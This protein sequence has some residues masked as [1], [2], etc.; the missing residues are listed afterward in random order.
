MPEG[1]FR[2]RLLEQAH[3]MPSMR[4]LDI[5]CGTGT[6]L[7]RAAEAQ[8]A[9]MLCGVDVDP[10]ILQ[11]ALKKTAANQI[12]ARLVCARGGLLPFRSESVDRA[13]STLMLHHLTQDEKRA[14]LNEARRVLRPRGELHIADWGPPHSMAMRIASLALRSFEHHD[15]TADNLS[16]LLPQLC[17]EAGFLDVRTT[18]RFRTMF[19]TLEL[20]A[21][22]MG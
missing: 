4:I 22:S 11:L 10:S 15:R 7:V 16:G 9:L 5:G 6:L 2:R 3:L 21:A 1:T 17:R 12:N 14:A 13:F 8:D 20:I 18:R 19:G